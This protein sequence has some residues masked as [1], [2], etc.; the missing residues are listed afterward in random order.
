MAKID[1]SAA[2]T[3]L[4]NPFYRQQRLLD[5]ISTLSSP[6]QRVDPQHVCRLI[7]ASDLAWS[8]TP[9]DD[10]LTWLY[11]TEPATV[12]RYADCLVLTVS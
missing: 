5:L 1:G 10:G 12:Q 8:V 11:L 2:R 3:R 7:V 4:S 9:N 6:R